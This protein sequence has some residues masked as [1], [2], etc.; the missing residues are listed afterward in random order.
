MLSGLFWSM[1]ERF[2]QQGILFITTIIIARI[3]TPADYGLIGMITIFIAISLS[4]IDSGFGQA[5]IQRQNATRKDESTVFFFNIIFGIGIYFLLFFIAPLIASFYKQPI[6]ISITRIMGLNLIINSLSLV[7]NALLTKTIDFKK[8]SKIT[9]ISVFISGIIGIIF[10]LKGFGVWALII[11][12]IIGNIVKTI[13]FW[14][15]SNWRP[16]LTFDFIS[17]RSLFSFG[18]KLLAAGLL[19]QFFDNIYNIIIGKIYTPASLGF[20]TQAKRIQE[21]PVTNTLAILQR[22][23]FPIYSTIQNETERLKNA[24]RKTIKAIVLVNFPLMIGMIICSPLLIKTLLTDKWL[25]TVPYLQLL[26]IIGMLYPLSAV[27][28]N[29]LKVKGRTDIFFYLEIVKKV[30][31]AL[32]ILVT[33]RYGIYIMIVGQVCTGFIGHFLNI[34]Y[35]GRLIKYSIREQT[36][37][38]AMY[39]FLASGVGVIVYLGGILLNPLPGVMKLIVQV[40]AFVVLYL[41]LT[42]IFKLEAYKDFRS[43]V[44]AKFLNIHESQINVA[45]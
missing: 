41:I 3:L 7:Q 37:D 1:L 20:Y 32:A 14:I 13:L 44:D 27:N 35:S 38:I 11:Q 16:L 24:Y 28:L 33:F 10:A 34:F 36:N 5:L 25:P 29:I 15:M 31:I 26:C 22:V 23:T 19:N 4:L 42:H 8:L 43:V 12:A 17:L 6:L 45:T 21:F 18:S 9:I 30:L 39:L 40:V 2:G